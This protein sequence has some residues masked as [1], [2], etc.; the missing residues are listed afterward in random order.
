MCWV[1]EEREQRG[2][3]CWVG[4]ES[5]TRRH[6]DRPTDRQTDRQTDKQT[7]REGGRDGGKEREGS[8][9]LRAALPYSQP[10]PSGVTWSWSHLEQQQPGVS[11]PV[12]AT[13]QSR[14]R[15]A[16]HE[17]HSCLFTLFVFFVCLFICFSFFFTIIT[18]S[19]C[20]NG[21]GVCSVLPIFR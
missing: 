13:L 7:D 8:L 11:P 17:E 14:G 6:A 1:G 21:E 10:A 5:D 16:H 20:V 9:G 19:L 18:F 12:V 2:E 15:E 4:E 3:V